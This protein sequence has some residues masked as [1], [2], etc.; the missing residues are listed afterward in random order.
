MTTPK[1]ERIAS[2]IILPAERIAQL[3][4]FAEAEGITITELIERW[5][6]AEIAAERLP[7]ILPNF[8]VTAVEGRVWFTVKD[9]SFPTMTPVQ[10]EQIADALLEIAEAKDT[11]GKKA[12]FGTGEDEISL[13]VARKRRGVLISGEDV[14]TKRAVKASLTPGMARDL[15][16]IIRNEAAKAAKYYAEEE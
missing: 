6:N 5:I 8:E 14:Q 7:D 16:R 15:A 10:A 1:R 2:T 9:F 3:R 13:K 11:V 12:M 4:T